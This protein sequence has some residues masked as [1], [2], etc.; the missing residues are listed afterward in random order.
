MCGCDVL[1]DKTHNPVENKRTIQHTVNCSPQAGCVLE[2]TW[3]LSISA[4]F[5]ETHMNFLHIPECTKQSK[6]FF[7]RAHM[8]RKTKQPSD[9][10]MEQK[11]DGQAAKI[12]QTTKRPHY[13]T[14]CSRKNNCCDGLNVLSRM[15]PHVHRRVKNRCFTKG[16]ILFPGVAGSNI[17]HLNKKIK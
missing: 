15:C 6:Y 12:T 8:F 13:Q 14:T 7:L 3:V 4:V 11:V 5:V 16:F 17:E 10:G 1:P 9:R 2:F